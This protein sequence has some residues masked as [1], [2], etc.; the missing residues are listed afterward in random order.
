MEEKETRLTA[1][2]GFELYC[3]RWHYRDNADKVVVCLHGIE[4]HSGAFRFMAPVLAEAGA[5]VY[6]FDRRGFGNSKEQG[7]ERGD[8]R[9][10]VRHLKDLDE[11]IEGVRSTHP[12]LKTF[13]FGHSIGC[14]YALRYAALN[15]GSVD[16]LVLAAPPVL[17]G[18]K[19]PATDALRLPFQQIFS[20]HSMY[21]LLSHWP[22]AFKDSEEYKLI[23]GDELCTGKF[24]IRW[25][26]RARTN[27]TTKMLRNA[28]RIEKPTLVLQGDSDIIALPSGTDR[29]MGRLAAKDKQLKTYRAA[30]HW[31]FHSI[32]PTASS[33]YSLEKKMEVSGAVLEWMRAH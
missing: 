30:D 8:T 21:D 14:A 16:G 31:L 27:L 23:L 33:R 22:Q 9:D 10:F 3:R 4:V 5:E 15:P 18:F 26:L 25:L 28:E 7:L 2:D 1:S 12:G 20:P 29:L 13:I 24:G 17:A 32:I 6:A 19:M 11:V